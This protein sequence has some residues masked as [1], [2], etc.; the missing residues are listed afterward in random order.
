[1]ARKSNKIK[2]LTSKDREIRNMGQKTGWFTAEQAN[3]L[4]GISKTRLDKLVNS[5]ILAK[6]IDVKYGECYK[7]LDKTDCR[8]GFY[9]RSSS[10]HHD[11]KLTDRY[12]QLNEIERQHC[13]TA[14]YY[15]REHN[16][17]VSRGAPD[18]VIATETQIVFLEAITEN[19]TTNMIEEKEEVAIQCG[20][21]LEK[22]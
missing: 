3:H 16:I 15:F 17:E 5:N 21:I 13:Y 10:P 18:L 9:H 11:L 2:C 6:S 12:L 8:G 7:V 14:D 20:A 19:Y 22:F 4:N 1:M